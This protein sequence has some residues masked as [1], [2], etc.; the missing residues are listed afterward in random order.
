[1]LLAQLTNR[2]IYCLVALLQH[3][4]LTQ[5]YCGN[6]GMMDLRMEPIATQVP[7]MDMT[8]AQL[9]AQRISFPGPL[10]D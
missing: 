1:M 6:I 3:R 5:E 8:A 9:A 7:G 10:L 2:V 4:W